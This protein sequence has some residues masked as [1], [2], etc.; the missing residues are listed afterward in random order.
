M[1]SEEHVIQNRSMNNMLV[2]NQQSSFMQPVIKC[3]RQ[4]SDKLC[5]PFIFSKR[6]IK[7]ALY[8]VHANLSKPNQNCSEYTP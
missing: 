1:K 4:V 3:Y 6:N 2:C 7:I 5:L 8:D